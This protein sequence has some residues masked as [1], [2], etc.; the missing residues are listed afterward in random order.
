[1]TIEQLKEEVIS[2]V[3]RLPDHTDRAW[4]VGIY[5]SLRTAYHL[6]YKRDQ[7]SKAQKEKRESAL[8]RVIEDSLL[9]PSDPF[10]A[11]EL[12]RAGYFFN[13]ALLR[14]V[15]LA[16]IGLKVL[17]KKCK[18]ETPPEENYWKLAKWYESNFNNELTYLNKARYQV[19]RYKHEPRDPT[20]ERELES[21]DEGILAFRELLSLMS[22]LAK[23]K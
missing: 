12:W 1:M 7:F 4:L 18:R 6:D 23:A 21:M 3:S 5:V 22:G 20:K 17:Y 9:T 16:E 15:A 2:L 10:P 13:N 14:M 11:Q 19:N 8:G